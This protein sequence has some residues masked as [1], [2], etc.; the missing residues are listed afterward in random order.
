MAR[1]KH[2]RKS[3]QKLPL[4]IM[5]PLALPVIDVA[6]RVS[7]GKFDSNDQKMLIY[8]MTGY[9]TATKTWNAVGPM[10]TYGPILLGVGVHK[11]V[12]KHVNRYIPKWL[13]VGL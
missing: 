4:A 8:N 13:P 6:K 7:D 5:I 2:M 9:N 11:F 10:Q 3:R 12:G 1:K